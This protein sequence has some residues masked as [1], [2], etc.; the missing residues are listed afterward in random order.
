M[1][2]QI[3]GNR[4]AKLLTC[5]TMG[6]AAIAFAGTV[7][8][9]ATVVTYPGPAGIPASDQFSVRVSDGA[10]WQDSFTYQTKG[11]TTQSGNIDYSFSNFEM[12][13][14]AVTVE[15]TFLKGN[16]TSCVVQPSRYNITPTIAGNKATFTMTEPRKV[17]VVINGNRSTECLVFANPPDPG[18]PK[19]A[20]YV[21]GPG[22]HN[23]GAV[24][25]ETGDSVYVKGG[26]YVKGCFRKG[27]DARNIRISGYGI[28]SGEALTAADMTGTDAKQYGVCVVD[29]PPD[30][31]IQGVTIANNCG[32]FVLGAADNFRIINTKAIAGP[33]RHTFNGGEGGVCLYQTNTK[34]GPGLMEGCF[35][36]SSDDSIILNYLNPGS[37]IKDCTT[38]TLIAGAVQ[39]GANGYM[40]LRD[41][42]V[43]GLNVLKGDGRVGYAIGCFYESDEVSFHDLTFRDIIVEDNSGVGALMRVEIADNAWARD[44]GGYG[45]IYNLTFKDICFKPAQVRRSFITSIRELNRIGN[46]VIDNVRINGTVVTETNFATFFDPFV[47]TY[48]IR[49]GRYTN[50]PVP[51]LLANPSFAKGSTDG[52]AAY[53]AAAC[54]IT[55]E[56]VVAVSDG[57]VRVCNRRDKNAGVS[58]DITSALLA[59]GPG[60]YEFK[61]MIRTVGAVLPI[62]M[63]VM[64]TDSNGT[65]EVYLKARNIRSD[66]DDPPAA[67]GCGSWGVLYYRQLYQA[68][69]IQWNGTLASAQLVI[70]CVGGT[71]TNDFYVDDCFM[72]KLPFSVTPETPATATPLSFRSGFETKQPLPVSTSK[73]VILS[74][75]EGTACQVVAGAGREGSAGLVLSGTGTGSNACHAYFAIFE[76][77]VTVEPDSI[78]RYWLKPENELGRCTGID[79]LFQDGSPLR[80]SAARGLDGVR[81]HP[82]QPKG[83][84]G[85]WRQIE[86]PIGQWLAGKVVRQVVLAFDHPG[87]KGPFKAVVDDVSIGQE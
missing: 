57:A 23:A 83:Q 42:T 30:S 62:R 49:F 16:I 46:V 72:R 59:N 55:G 26:A 40:E 22:V 85:Q 5:I 58:Q 7:H 21:Y 71:S 38:I 63:S 19:G 24:T 61:S 29:L 65:R 39:F 8:A 82:S 44:F 12:G 52:W 11:G 75:V 35:V 78:L 10:S 15:V 34:Y 73:P 43:T 3:D 33:K 70:Q 32:T 64:I 18:E 9:A 51:N 86:I 28:I 67:N 25:L 47:N 4:A 1:Q 6:V 84:V 74:N 68:K 69:K 80:D 50:A 66:V 81:V 20:K 2:K 87:S 77:A 27:K 14:G 76:T 54:S 48:N 13:G 31:S 60:A 53:P 79:L 36:Q 45:E 41:I 17:E 56:T 37:V